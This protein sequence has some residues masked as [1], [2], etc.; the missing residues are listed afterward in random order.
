VLAPA[1][2]TE[3][4]LAIH[5]LGVVVAFGVTFTYP[6]LAIAGNREKR[7][8]PTLHRYQVAVSRMVINPGLLVILIAGIA[9]A[10]ERH[11]WSSF[12]VGWG[13][14]AV[15]GRSAEPARRLAVEG[16]PVSATLAAE[17]AALA[18]AERVAFVLHDPFGLPFGQIGDECARI[19]FRCGLQGLGANAAVHLFTGE[20]KRVLQQAGPLARGP[21]ASRG[22]GHRSDDER[23]RLECLVTA[24]RGLAC[25]LHA[26]VCGSRQ[27]GG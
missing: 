27:S 16:F 21:E 13:I 19:A 18:P 1:S 10:S 15:G 20:A 3:A 25:A 7:A 8:M 4:I 26:T 11:Q 9:L 24:D 6:L 23:P 17:A 2:F 5:I 14:A 22:V 12:Y